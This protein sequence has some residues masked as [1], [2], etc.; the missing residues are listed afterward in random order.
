MLLG[1]SDPAGAARDIGAG[2]TCR[3]SQRALR[4]EHPHIACWPRDRSAEEKTRGAIVRA[5]G[6]GRILKKVTLRGHRRGSMA[7]HLYSGCLPSAPNV[8]AAIF[9]ATHGSV[10]PETSASTRFA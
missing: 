6:D 2:T 7:F 3:N 5:D 1:G 8:N 10:T 9:I 4:D